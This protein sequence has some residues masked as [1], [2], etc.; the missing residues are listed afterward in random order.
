M[1]EKSKEE[2]VLNQLAALF[3]DDEEQPAEAP[4]E[5]TEGTEQPAEGAGVDVAALQAENEA[6]K[7]Q[8]Q[9]YTEQASKLLDARV[10]NLSD[11]KKGKMQDLFSALK[12]DNPLQQLSILHTIQGATSAPS[13]DNARHSANSVSTKPKNLKELRGNL[14]KILSNANK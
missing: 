5:A 3:L 14:K 8:L 4:A 7:A 11:K 10:K 13:V 9:E 2:E 1:T 6:L 12:A